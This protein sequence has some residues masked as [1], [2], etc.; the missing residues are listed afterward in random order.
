[1]R[2]G[3]LPLTDLQDGQKPLHNEPLRNHRLEFVVDDVSCVD[4]FMHVP[5]DDA[6]RQFEYATRFQLQQHS[7][8]VTG[9]LHLTLAL[10]ADLAL[11][12]VLVRL[13]R[14]GSNWKSPPQQ[15][16]S[17]TPDRLDIDFEI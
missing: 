11:A 6:L 12:A 7:G 8:M 4:L 1:F 15:I 9:D 3:D 14:I 17:L 16:A 5:R 13:L 2:L 10:I